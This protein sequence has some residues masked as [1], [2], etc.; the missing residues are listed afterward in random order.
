MDKKVEGVFYKTVPAKEACQGCVALAS[1][2]GAVLGGGC[3]ESCLCVKLGDVCS[4]QN[5]IWKRE[6][7]DV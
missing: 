1:I 6:A 2:K 3:V 4:E 7:L 5:L